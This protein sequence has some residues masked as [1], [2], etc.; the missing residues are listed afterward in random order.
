MEGRWTAGA[1]KPMTDQFYGSTLALRSLKVSV[2][3]S[4]AVSP[5]PLPITSIMEV[6]LLRA[7]GIPRSMRNH[8]MGILAAGDQGG[9]FGLDDQ[10]LSSNALVSLA[11]DPPPEVGTVQRR[12]S[13][14]MLR[15]FPFGLR[16]S[17]SNMSP[18]P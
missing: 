18:L 10:Q 3:L 13:G 12:T 4:G 17:G 2:C 6:T 1:G 15:P 14:W 9:Q 7:L 11:R 16:F 5:W 8:I